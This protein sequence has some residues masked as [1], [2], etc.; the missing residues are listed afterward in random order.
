MSFHQDNIFKTEDIF[1]KK[2]QG[3]PSLAQFLC[4]NDKGCTKAVVI[5]PA[6]SLFKTLSTGSALP[7]ISKQEH[8]EL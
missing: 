8:M 2:E 5:S 6:T 4:Y 3:L 1:V 7:R